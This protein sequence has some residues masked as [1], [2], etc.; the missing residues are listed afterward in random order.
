MCCHGDAVLEVLISSTNLADNLSR[1]FH[2]SRQISRWQISRIFFV[3]I[4]ADKSQSSKKL[5]RAVSSHSFSIE[6]IVS[7]FLT[8]HQVVS[9]IFLHFSKHRDLISGIW[10]ELKILGVGSSRTGSSRLYLSRIESESS[11]ILVESSRIGSYGVGVGSSES[12]SKESRSR[13]IQ[14][15]IIITSKN[16][17]EIGVKSQDWARG[18]PTDP[19]NCRVWGER[20]TEVEA[21]PVDL[22]NDLIRC[23][24]LLLRKGTEIREKQLYLNYGSVRVSSS[25]TP[26]TDAVKEGSPHH[27]P[28]R[29]YRKIIPPVFRAPIERG[30]SSGRSQSTRTPWWGGSTLGLTMRARFDY[31]NLFR[32]P[33]ILG[34]GVASE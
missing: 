15:S 16:E 9:T 11:R 4:S 28:T 1:E 25:R 22:G 18:K 34:V 17:G 27:P 13:R 3:D 6:A 12:E 33:A 21:R 2:S 10:A 7:M 31:G 23:S 24:L 26:A 14:K 19:G 32:T 20:G 8:I 5:F 29:E 30:C